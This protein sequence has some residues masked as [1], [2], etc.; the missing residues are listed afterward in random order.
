VRVTIR[1]RS[2]DGR[3]HAEEFESE[4]AG[5]KVL[6]TLLEAHRASGLTVAVDRVV[7]LVTD[8]E[9]NFV[10]RLEFKQTD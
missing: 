7:Y 8:R 10:Q 1:T 2:P 4:P 9:G 6:D 5:R 3:H